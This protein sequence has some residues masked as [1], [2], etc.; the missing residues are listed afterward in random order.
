MHAVSPILFVHTFRITEKVFDFAKSGTLLDIGC[1]DGNNMS[2]FM[3]R[4]G[5]RTVGCDISKERLEIAKNYGEVVLGCGEKLPFRGEY[6][7]V[8]SIYHVLH[9]VTNPSSIL[10]EIFRVLKR[11]GYLIMG[12]S[13]EDNPFIRIG[14]TIHPSYDGVSVFSRFRRRE[15]RRLIAKSGFEI[16][17]EYTLGFFW[18]LL[19]ESPFWFSSLDRKFTRTA[20]FLRVLQVVSMLDMKISDVTKKMHAYYYALAMKM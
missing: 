4:G 16:I 5:W 12:E 7:D 9:H 19:L 2:R 3:E 14:R 15:L 6:F 10:V 13:V 11:K 8:V 1:G 17:H 18:Y 20:L